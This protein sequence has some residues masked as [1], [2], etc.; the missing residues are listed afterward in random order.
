MEPTR[1][2]FCVRHFEKHLSTEFGTAIESHLALLPDK[3]AP[4]TPFLRRLENREFDSLADWFSSLTSHVHSVADSMGADSPASL[5]L[6][7]LL[8]DIGIDCGPALSDND[9]R[10]AELDSFVNRLESVAST[11]PNSL[12]EFLA[13]ADEGDDAV[14]PGF[15]LDEEEE[16]PIWQRWSARLQELVDG[17]GDVIEVDVATLGPVTLRKLREFVA[18]HAAEKDERGEA[19]EG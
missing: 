11:L 15:F 2:Q 9:R 12:D 13:V 3:D 16:L 10:L 5:C 4:L 1:W 18:K 17:S 14:L 8:R 7:T 6:L 19:G